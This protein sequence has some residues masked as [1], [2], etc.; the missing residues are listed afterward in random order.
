LFTDSGGALS[1]S[2]QRL[3][4]TLLESVLRAEVQWWE[5]NF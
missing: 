4:I 1:V 5:G 2:Q 3:G